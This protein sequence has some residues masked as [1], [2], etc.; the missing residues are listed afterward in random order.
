MIITKTWLEEWLP[1]SDIASSDIE[2]TLNSIGLEV[3]NSKTFSI[4]EGIVVGY[5]ESCQKHPDATKLNICQVNIGTG[6]RQIVCGGK[7]VAAGQYVPV[8]T[9]GAIMPS[10]LEIKPVKLRGVDSDGMI[11]SAEE[12]N[13]PKLNDG[14]LELDDSIGKLEI[15]KPL[16]EYDILNDTMIEIEL[17]ANRGDC[18]SIYGIARDL[19]AA[20]DIGLKPFYPEEYSEHS[21]GIGRILQFT[22]ENIQDVDLNYRAIEYKPFELPLKIRFRL[23]LIELLEDNPLNNIINYTTYTTGVILRN[24]TK[25]AFLHDKNGKGHIKIEND[26]GKVKVTGHDKTLS[27]VGI[28]QDDDTRATNDPQTVVL[29]ASYIDP[30]NVSQLVYENNFIQIFSI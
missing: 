16:N 10:G 5:V 29:E 20:Y 28:I 11:C 9:I 3:D 27:I 26:N 23:A 7:N 8:A 17:T 18:L 24:Y 19:S 25:S 22:H 14:I 30:K 4:P 21:I 15:G 12:I 2:A 13:L 6:L 1:V